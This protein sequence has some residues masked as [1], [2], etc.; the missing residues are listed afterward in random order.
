MF[1]GFVR[2]DTAYCF[3]STNC[4]RQRLLVVA[5][6]FESRAGLSPSHRT[7]THAR[8]R[9]DLSLQGKG[10]LRPAVPGSCVGKGTRETPVGLA[11]GD[12]SAALE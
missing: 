12:Q 5:A 11:D 8:R 1:P 4:T 7:S 9:R 2:C 6:L 10:A 3:V